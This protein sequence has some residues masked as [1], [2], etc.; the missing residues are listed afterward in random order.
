MPKILIIN[1]VGTE[2]WNKI[3]YEGIKE[4]VN[5]QTEVV[6]RNLKDAPPAIECEYDKDLASPF[7]IRE[8]GKACNEGFDAV[9]INCFDDPGLEASREI[10]K[11][12]VLGVGETSIYTALNLGFKIGII[13]TG[14][15]ARN[16]YYRRAIKLG[17]RNRI[18]YTSGVGINVLNLRK[19]LRRTKEEVRKEI[20]NAIQNYDVDIIVLGCTGFLGLAKELTDEIG[21]PVIDPTLITV[22]LAEAYIKLGLSHSRINLFNRFLNSY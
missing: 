8:V 2:F 20:I 7:V 6:V 14:E 12:L 22:K 10:S 4:V 13:S 11:T 1:P 21:L 19:D 3:T 18:V 9:I 5:P 16:I 17:L 15:S